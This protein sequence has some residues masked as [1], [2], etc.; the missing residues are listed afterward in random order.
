VHLATAI[1]SDHIAPG[2]T[3]FRQCKGVSDSTLT[4]R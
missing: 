2:Q 4:L 3:L 1:L